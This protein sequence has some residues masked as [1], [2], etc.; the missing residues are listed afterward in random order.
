MTPVMQN[1]LERRSVRAYTPE[2]PTHDQLEQIVLAGQ[3]APSGKNLQE[4]H[5]IVVENPEETRRLAALMGEELGRKSYDLY[6][7]P[8]IILAAN[9]KDARNAMADCCAA[10]ENMMLAAHDMGLG[11]CWINQFRDLWGNP[12]VESYLEKLGLPAGYAVQCSAIFGHPAKT[13]TAPARKPNTVT[14]VK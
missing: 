3:F 11:S 8:C 1:L 9:K 5:F 7:A 13:P 14:F 2:P 4:W 10:L 6:G 12:R